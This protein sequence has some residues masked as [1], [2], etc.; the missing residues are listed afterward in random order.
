MAQIS[1]SGHA[2]NVANFEELTT[3]VE[4]Y[5]EGYNPTREALKL[6]ALLVVL[7]NSKKAIEAVNS[8]L[9]AYVR[10][11]ALREEAFAPLSKLVTR[12][13]NSLKSLATT[14][15]IHENALTYARKIQGKRAV[16]KRT[17]EQIEADAAAG[18]E[19]I[20]KSA[21]QMS[22]DNRLDN[23]DKLIKFLSSVEEYAPNEADLKVVSLESLY[24][25][26]LKK[27]SEVIKSITP[28]NNS[29]IARDQ[30]LYKEGTGLVDIAC[31]VK[32]Y[33]KSVYGA[34]SSQYSQVSKISF[35]KR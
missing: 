5:G 6:V 18:K 22:Y 8:A 9:P 4:G 16:A 35:K 31:D 20:E 12:I 25:D 29:R 33:V 30:A 27:N 23:F 26:L 10:A 24:A 1:E 7:S 13:T 21:S 3:K 14:D 28:L 34:S 11:V 2:K 17:P 19:I 32:A 15:H